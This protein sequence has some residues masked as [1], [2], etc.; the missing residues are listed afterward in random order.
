MRSFFLY[1]NS[2]F[3]ICLQTFFQ[4][5]FGYPAIKT[6]SV[7]NDCDVV[8]TQGLQGTQELQGTQGTQGLQGTQGTTFGGLS[9]NSDD[10]TTTL[11]GEEYQNTLYSEDDML[12]D[13][14]LE[15][16]GL[17]SEGDGLEDD[18]G[19]TSEGDGLEDHGL[20]IEDDGLEDDGLTIEDTDASLSGGGE[21]S[22]G[23]G[24]LTSDVLEAGET[25][26]CTDGYKDESTIQDGSKN[27]TTSGDTV[28][29]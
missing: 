27:E 21:V 19:L 23:D 11:D 18:D 8:G 25:L 15:D 5:L 16:D 3:Y 24:G 20:T 6:D 14:M 7:Y 26:D 22:S 28:D 10:D 17:A 12:E 2:L 1:M 4:H 13:D 29:C 9:E